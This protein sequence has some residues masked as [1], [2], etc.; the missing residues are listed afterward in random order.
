LVKYLRHT[1]IDRSR[2]DLCI[3][4]ASF[5][6][7]YP[8]SWYLDLVSNN[9]EGLVKGDYEMVM[10]LTR[11]K[12]FGFNFLLQPILAQ[13]LGIFSKNQP[14]SSE[15][16]D[17][18]EAI[19]PG[20]RYIDICL[21]KQNID[22]PGKIRQY[23][24]V[25]HELDLK[26]GEA[27]NN[28][29]RRNLQKAREH[30]FI[31]RE[32]NVIQYLDL[33]YSAEKRVPVKRDYLQNLFEGLESMK[34]AQAFGVFLD[35]E[36]QSAAILGYSN[37]RVIYMNGCSGENGKENRSM[38]VL[39]DHL[40]DSSRSRYSIFDFE[41]SNLPGVARFFEGFGAT[42]TSYPRIVKTKFPFIRPGK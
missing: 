31:V 23:E 34:R 40:I 1:E 12:K 21:N 18:I 3:E 32:I 39:M 28:N 41:G 6:T 7:L 16:I 27:Y 9:W 26:A 29:T 20:F 35:E 37:S 10:P 11:T 14:D 17:F 4:N 38:F 33:K 30:S 19:P 2:W 15:I 22:L 36:L 42:R 24:R 25:N 5:E 8:Y 13:Q